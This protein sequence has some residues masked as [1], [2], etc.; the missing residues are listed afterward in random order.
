MQQ[1]G[2]FVSFVPLLMLSIVIGIQSHFLAKEKGRNVPLW[3]E[4]GFVPVVNLFCIWY[5]TGAANFR[6]EKKVDELLKRS[7]VT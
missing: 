2:G 3:T 6:L 5:F 4:L 7:Q 1:P